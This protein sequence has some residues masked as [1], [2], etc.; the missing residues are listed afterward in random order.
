MQTSLSATLF[1][2]I[3]NMVFLLYGT[4]DTKWFTPIMKL[5]IH[6][7]FCILTIFNQ[8]WHITLFFQLCKWFCKKFQISTTLITSTIIICLNNSWLN[9][10][11]ILETNNCFLFQ[12][13]SLKCL[14]QQESAHRYFN[15]PVHPTRSESIINDNTLTYPQ[16]LTTASAQV[17]YTKE[18]HDTL[19]AAAQN[20]TPSDWHYQQQY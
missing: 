14:S 5:Y 12:K 18:I 20:I 19:I 1:H 17:A 15:L 9:R 7:L 6:L 3:G 16:F 8:K 10:I 11:W 2:I 4:V 13:T